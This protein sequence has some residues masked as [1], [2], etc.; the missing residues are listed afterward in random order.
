[1]EQLDGLYEALEAALKQS[2][3]A[4][5][6]NALFDMPSIR[7][8]ARTVNRVSDYLGNMWRK[9]D[10]IRVPAPP[11]KGTRARWAY[12][13]KGRVQARIKIKDIAKGAEFSAGKVGTLL[14]RPS[15]EITEEGKNIV[16]TTPHCTITI[17]P[18]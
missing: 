3:E 12:A 14:S 7:A 5:D 2:D 17:K 1:M 8:H 4:L 18:N 13:W 11:I 10:V 16:I 9:G 6:C 15:L